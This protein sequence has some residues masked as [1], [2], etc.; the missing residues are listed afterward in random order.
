[1]TVRMKDMKYPCPCCGYL[2][3]AERPGSYQICPICFWEDDDVQL[4]IPTMAGGANKV[5][6][7]D[8]QTNFQKIGASEERLLQYVRKPND[9]DVRD[10]SWRIFDRS[11][12]PLEIS[13][14]EFVSFYRSDPD[15]LY[16]WRSR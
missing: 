5:S 16:Y 15:K 13:K 8:A 6:L 3:F 10:M 4:R 11:K 12:D 2:E 14:E 7:I 9:E 1:M